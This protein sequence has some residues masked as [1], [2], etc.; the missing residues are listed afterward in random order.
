[1]LNKLYIRYFF[2]I[3][4]LRIYKLNLLGAKIGNNVKSFGFFTIHRPTN[5]TIGDNSTINYGVHLNC[6][7]QITI[8]NDV[9]ISTNVQLHTS[10]LDITSYPR[11][12]I[13]APIVIKNNVWLAS[14]C[15][16]SAGVCLGENTIVGANSVVTKDL[17]PNCFYAGNPARLIKK[18]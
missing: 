18:L 7:E 3:N 1:M 8:G 2:L 11:R 15:V 14:G 4:K 13:Y 17:E 16:V 6:S 10:K 9:R 5:L 12:H